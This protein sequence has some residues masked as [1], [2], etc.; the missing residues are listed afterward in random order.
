[1]IAKEA[2]YLVVDTETTGI[3]PAEHRAVEVAAVLI[4]AR[5]I[6][7]AFTTYLNPGRSIPPAASAVHGLV[8]DDVKDAPT[9]EASLPWLNALASKADAIVAHNAPFD[10]SMLPG[11]VEKP[12]LDTLRFSRKL[13]PDLDGHGNQTMRYHMKLRTPEANGMPAHRA[14]ADAYVT[15][16]LLIA[17]LEVDEARRS[18][19][20]YV[21]IELVDLLKHLD[22][23]NLLTT[24]TF[25]K[26]K[27]TPWA[28][29]PRDYLDWL[30]RSEG[31]ATSDPDQKHTVLH[32][33][34]A[35]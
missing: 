17:L 11:L 5:Q 3:D 1:M 24:C 2:T 26:H 25:G 8:D 23:P 18:P 28:Q 31:W 7:S 21:S 4:K 29:V 16:R 19:N 9:L 22:E 35:R 10:R 30:R 34:G 27:G 13:F 33:L 20:S 32:Y 15:A 12:W 6:T 14:L